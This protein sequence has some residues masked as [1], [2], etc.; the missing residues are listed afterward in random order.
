MT[1]EALVGVD[2]V[3]VMER[4]HR[5]RLQRRFGEHLRSARVVCLDIADDYDFMD[6][7]LVARLEKRAGPHLER[8]VGGMAGQH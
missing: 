5:T 1:A 6:P 2:L 8:L 4:A 3:V 7:A